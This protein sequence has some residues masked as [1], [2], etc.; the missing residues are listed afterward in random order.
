MPRLSP[1]DSLF[2][3][4]RGKICVDGIV[5]DLVSVFVFEDQGVIRS[6]VHAMKYQSRASAGVMLGAEVGMNMITRGIDGEIIV[7]IPLHRIKERER[8]Y[9]QAEMIARGVS[10]MT[11]IPCVP[12]AVVRTKQTQTQT[13]LTIDQ[14]RENMEGA[15]DIGRKYAASMKNAT[16]ILVDDVITTGST[17]VACASVLKGAGAQRVVAASVAL[18]R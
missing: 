4:T 16:C 13:M 9:N 1:S 6:L 3:E 11:G 12:R 15:F 5:D 8:G 14:R 17:I 10:K 2:E 18:A 7:P